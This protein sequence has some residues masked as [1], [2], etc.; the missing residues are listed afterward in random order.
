MNSA[1]RKSQARCSF[2][3]TFFKYPLRGRVDHRAPIPSGAAGK[4]RRST[5]G[6]SAGPADFGP[7]TLILKGN[8]KMS[9]A[10]EGRTPLLFG[11]EWVNSKTQ[12]TRL[13]LINSGHHFCIRKVVK[14]QADKTVSKHSAVNEVFH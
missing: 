10:P 13:T 6:P 7:D 3:W 5:A 1:A 8:P 9:P 12:N 4:S 11:Y 14:K 2:Q